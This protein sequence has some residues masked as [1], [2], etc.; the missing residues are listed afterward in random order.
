MCDFSNEKGNDGDAGKGRVLCD[1]RFPLWARRTAH[2]PSNET[3]VQPCKPCSRCRGRP[4][5]SGGTHGGI[6]SRGKTPHPRELT[7]SA[8]TQGTSP[9]SQQD[10]DG[11][12]RRG[13][14]WRKRAARMGSEEAPQGTARWTASPRGWGLTVRPPALPQ[15]TGGPPGDREL[16]VTGPGQPAGHVPRGSPRATVSKCLQGQRCWPVTAV[17]PS[18]GT[19]PLWC[20]CPGDGAGRSPV[21]PSLGP[22]EALGGS[23][24]RGWGFRIRGTLTQVKI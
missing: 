22:T 14:T 21:F 19:P 9:T 24:E 13:E 5:F 16:P 23:A 18:L 12:G 17:F 6:Y 7:V 10:A 11:R 4:A 8:G 15:D 20:P 3:P 1:P 2:R